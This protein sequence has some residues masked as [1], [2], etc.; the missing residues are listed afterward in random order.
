MTTARDLIQD[1]LKEAT[2]LGVGQTALAEDINDGMKMLRRMLAQ[3]QK[4]RWM[5]PAAN[6]S[7]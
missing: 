7:S 6:I 5:V 1:A 3:W 4:R 2:I